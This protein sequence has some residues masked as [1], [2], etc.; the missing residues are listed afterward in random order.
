MESPKIVRIVIVP[1]A[2][3]C[4]WTTRNPGLWKPTAIA[5][6]A[7]ENRSLDKALQVSSLKHQVKNGERE[8]TQ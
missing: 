4:R 2:D 8:V 7:Y 3:Y 1:I 5:S 6:L